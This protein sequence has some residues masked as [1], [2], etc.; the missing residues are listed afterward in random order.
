M[1][2]IEHEQIEIVPPGAS[3][4]PSRLDAGPGSV[5]QGSDILGLMFRPPITIESR[6]QQDSASA[7]GTSGLFPFQVT[8]SS[9]D[10]GPKTTVRAGTVWIAG[11]PSTVNPNSGSPIE[12]DADTWYGWILIDRIAK[13]ATWGCG[14]TI[15][16]A[17]ASQEPWPIVK[18]TLTDGAISELEQTWNGGDIHYPASV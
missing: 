5:F 1:N 9:D 6:E 16:D 3:Q 7:S 8:D 10:D 2:D 15:P 14:A 4:F 17:T 18:V 12:V 11:V 13:T